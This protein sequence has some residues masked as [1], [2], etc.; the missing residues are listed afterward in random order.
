MCRRHSNPAS[1]LPQLEPG[2]ADPT[3][4]FFLLIKKT[5][6]LFLLSSFP[7]AGQKRIYISLHAGL[8]DEHKTL[9]I[10]AVGKCLTPEINL[11]MM[12]DFCRLSSSLTSAGTAQAEGLSIANRFSPSPFSSPLV[13]GWLV[14]YVQT[15]S[16]FGFCCFAKE[17]KKNIKLMWQVALYAN[18]TRSVRWSTYRHL[19]K[20]SLFVLSYICACRQAHMYTYKNTGQKIATHTLAHARTRVYMDRVVFASKLQC[21]FVQ[22]L[23]CK[24]KVHCKGSLLVCEWGISKGKLGLLTGTWTSKKRMVCKVDNTLNPLD[25]VRWSGFYPSQMETGCH[26]DYF[27]W[28]KIKI[29]QCGSHLNWIP[30]LHALKKKEIKNRKKKFLFQTQT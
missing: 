16:E 20:W 2:V 18:F 24:N 25:Q 28:R 7:K 6:A 21:H 14:F 5:K 29:R 8:F 3:G 1:N 30:Y 12:M 22:S 13:S 4:P 9:K 10:P 11:Q 27:I 23:K 15:S 17:R 19:K 26:H